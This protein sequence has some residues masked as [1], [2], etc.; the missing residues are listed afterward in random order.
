MG[1]TPTKQ[2]FFTPALQTHS[3]SHAVMC[4]LVLTMRLRRGF[5]PVRLWRRTLDLELRKKSRKIVRWWPRQESN[6][7]LELRKLLYYPLYYEAGGAKVIF[8]RY[9]L[10]FFGAIGGFRL[11]LSDCSG[12]GFQNSPNMR[13]HVP[14]PVGS[15]EPKNQSTNIS[16]SLPLSRC[17]VWPRADDAPAAHVSTLIFARGESSGPGIPACRQAGNLNLELRKLLYYPLYYEAGLQK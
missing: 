12:N 14:F 5:L 16:N 7:D 11:N 10:A 6:L 17:I 8:Q 13:V 9:F 3:H 2:E 1:K 15:P 4:G